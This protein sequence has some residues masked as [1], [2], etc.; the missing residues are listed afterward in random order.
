VTTT[1]AE[2]A[3]LLQSEIKKWGPIVKDAGIQPE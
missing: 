3:A 2:A 1:P